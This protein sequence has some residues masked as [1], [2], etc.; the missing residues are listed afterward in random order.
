MRFSQ[1]VLLLFA[2]QTLLPANAAEPDETQEQAIAVI[3]KLGMVQFGLLEGNTLRQ[4]LNSVIPNEGGSSPKNISP[5][6][7]W[8]YGVM[9]GLSDR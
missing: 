3:K 4:T 7:L 1:I 5:I 8:V 6:S 2:A 9:R